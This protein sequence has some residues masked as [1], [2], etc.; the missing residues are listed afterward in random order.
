MCVSVPTPDDASAVPV[1]CSV[2]VPDD[3]PRLMRKSAATVLSVTSGDAVPWVG[4]T[5]RTLSVNFGAARFVLTVTFLSELLNPHSM[6]VAVLTTGPIKFCPA[7]TLAALIVKFTVPELTVTLLIVATV[8]VT[9][10]D[11]LL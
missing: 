11:L 1:Y 3:L 10:C 7:V 4:A 6:L 2:H 9:V 8:T 5:A